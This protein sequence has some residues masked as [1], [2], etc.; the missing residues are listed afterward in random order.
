M[1]V[2]AGRTTEAN[3][4]ALAVTISNSS[5]TLVPASIAEFKI[6]TEE[7]SRVTITP[8]IPSLTSWGY[9]L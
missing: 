3:W 8:S 4:V 1:V 7:M 6:P 5:G 9:K 2:K